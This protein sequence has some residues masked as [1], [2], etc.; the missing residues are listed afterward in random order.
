MAKKSNTKSKDTS[1]GRPKP[2]T[3]KISVT[4]DSKRKYG[5][6]GKCKK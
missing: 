2:L 4:R 6:G 5:K 1:S 3:P